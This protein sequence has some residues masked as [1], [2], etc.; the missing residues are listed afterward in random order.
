MAE[1][2]LEASSRSHPARSLGQ[3]QATPSTAPDLRTSNGVASSGVT[4]GP[5]IMVL[6]QVRGS[7]MTRGG[8]MIQ[9]TPGAFSLRGTRVRRLRGA[10]ER[11][12]TQGSSEAR[13]GGQPRSIHYRDET[14]AHVCEG[15][16]SPSAAATPTMRGSI[17]RCSSHR[18]CEGFNSL[19]DGCVRRVR[20]VGFRG[21]QRN[22]R[23]RPPICARQTEWLRRG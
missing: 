19:G 1:S 4:R 15:D 13:R 7:A 6:A 5:T 20:F 9:A 2:R 23:A 21:Y 14:A 8:S 12:G 3:G 17:S 16:P 11:S 18:G 10:P 22:A